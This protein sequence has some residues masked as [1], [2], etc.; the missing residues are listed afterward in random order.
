MK[1]NYKELH[2]KNLESIGN[3]ECF[4]AEDNNPYP[5]C[6]GRGWE[7]CASCGKWMELPGPYDND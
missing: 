5:L 1:E 7:E 2:K 4:L 3:A 6:K